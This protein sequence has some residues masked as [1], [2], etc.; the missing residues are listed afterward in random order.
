MARVPQLNNLESSNATILWNSPPKNLV[1]SFLGE[2]EKLTIYILGRVIQSAIKLSD[3]MF[4]NAPSQSAT[5]ILSVR[6]K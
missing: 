6:L 5:H 1:F 4:P 3:E 2:I